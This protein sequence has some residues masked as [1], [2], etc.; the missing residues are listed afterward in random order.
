MNNPNCCP[1]ALHTGRHSLAREGDPD[2]SPRDALS[3]RHQWLMRS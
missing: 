2:Y 1:V 3:S